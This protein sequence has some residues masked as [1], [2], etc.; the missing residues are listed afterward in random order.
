[1]DSYSAGSQAPST[2]A[3]P[4]LLRREQLGRA[5]GRRGAHRR[6]SATAVYAGG[7]QP[8][9]CLGH[10]ACMS[11]AQCLGAQHRQVRWAG[12]AASRSARGGGQRRVAAAQPRH[13]VGP[14]WCVCN[15]TCPGVGAAG[16][17]TTCTQL[18]QRSPRESPRTAFVDAAPLQIHRCSRA[19][20]SICVHHDAG[21]IASSPSP[22]SCPAAG[23][24][25]V[26][27]NTR[28]R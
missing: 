16:A 23:A 20:A 4:A 10:E 14:G 25:A 21:G 17:A 1:M 24:A 12:A 7:G 9:R 19:L 11:L 15:S 3:S 13:T 6:R 8:A 28:H 26:E 18:R 2:R 5:R 27:A 22:T